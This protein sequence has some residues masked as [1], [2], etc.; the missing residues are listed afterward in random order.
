MQGSKKHCQ[1]FKKCLKNRFLCELVQI[2]YS[3]SLEFITCNDRVCNVTFKT[4]KSVIMLSVILAKLFQFQKSYY[5][6]QYNNNVNMTFHR[7]IM[8]TIFFQVLSILGIKCQAHVKSALIVIDVQN[9]F[10]PGGSLGVPD[11]DSVVHVINFVRQSNIFDMVVTTQDWHCP[12]HVS[13]TSQ[14]P[15]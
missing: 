12:D 14:H 7:E 8:Y 10:I 11:G 13:F 3:F 1:T 9:C 2:Y 4:Q 5:I 15:K 6:A